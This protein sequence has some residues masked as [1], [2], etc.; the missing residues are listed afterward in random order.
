MQIFIRTHGD[1]AVDYFSE[2]NFCFDFFAF[3]F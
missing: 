1:L 3:F 2:E